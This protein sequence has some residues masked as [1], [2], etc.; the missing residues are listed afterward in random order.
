MRWRGLNTK[1]AKLARL[2]QQR[3]GVCLNH[4][5]RRGYLKSSPGPDQL[6]LWEILPEPVTGHE[7]ARAI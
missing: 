1:D 7:G 4:W 2:M 6:L 5:R 3:C